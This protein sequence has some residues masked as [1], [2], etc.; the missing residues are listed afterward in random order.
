MDL[1]A[2]TLLLMGGS[3]YSQSISAYAKK[4]GFK[5]VAV[6]NVENSAYKMISD[7]SFMIDTHDIDAVVKIVREEHCDG[8][9]VGA[10][11]ANIIPAITVA[12]RTGIHFYTDRKLWNLLSN[13][14]A[15]KDLLTAHGLDVTKEYSLTKDFNPSDLAQ[16]EYPVIIKPVDGSG[17]RGIS[18]CSNEEELKAGYR[19]ACSVSWTDSA[20]VEKYIT[21]M[22][23]MFIHY[24]VVDGVFSLS[25]TFDR[26]LN[27]SQGGF[28]GMAVAYNYPSVY[29]KQYME[30]VNAKMIAALKAAGIQNGAIN[31]QCFTDGTHYFFY[32]SGFR[33]GGEQMYFFTQE[34]TGIS[35]FEM[36]PN[37]AL[38]GKM[39]QSPKILDKDDPLFKRPCLSLYIPLKPGKITVLSGVDELRKTKGILNITEMAD[40]GTVIAGDGS[41]GQVCLRMHLMEDTVEAL[42]CLVDKVNTT[43]K[44]LDEN[45]NDMMLEKF[46]LRKTAYYQ[47][48]T[49]MIT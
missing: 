45:G 24:T 11:E 46:N 35:V 43:L 22:T 39:A 25:A 23:D 30:T 2:K 27:F 1:T 48:Y 19:R 42:A 4:A 5:T 18:V 12:E 9:F 29:T 21:G 37:Q 41:L 14:R 32:E 3:A 15:F 49:E 13:K 38:T 6:G 28:T 8:I 34:L 10:S 26:N 7:R 33:L 40:V 16:I 31:I 17:A 47:Q 36:M 20:V 44:I